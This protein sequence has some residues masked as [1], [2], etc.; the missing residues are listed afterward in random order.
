MRMLNE[1]RST[2]QQSD[3][4]HGQLVLFKA[5]TFVLSSTP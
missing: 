1:D 5:V 2:I 3:T 4:E